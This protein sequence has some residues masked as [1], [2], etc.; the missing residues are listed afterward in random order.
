VQLVA[1]GAEARAFAADA[2]PTRIDGIGGGGAD[3]A[4][5]RAF[6]ADADPARIDGI[7]GGG[8]DG[9]EARA[10]AADADP[11]RIGCGC[12]SRTDLC[13]CL[14]LVCL[15]DHLQQKNVPGGV[16][17]ASQDVRV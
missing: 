7:G 10:F 5:A 2:D 17:R 8:A 13:Y 1:D 9:A 11:A 14:R 6:A 16:G 3:G 4:E 12:G 15:H